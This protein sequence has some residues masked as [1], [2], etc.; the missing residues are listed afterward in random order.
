MAKLETCDVFLPD[1][2]VSLGFR[3]CEGKWSLVGSVPSRARK[4]RNAEPIRAFVRR[5]RARAR[6]NLH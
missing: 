5:T 4:P 3:F 2:G 6:R 1:L